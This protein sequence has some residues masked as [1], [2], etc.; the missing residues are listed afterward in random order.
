[1][2]SPETKQQLINLEKGLPVAADVGIFGADIPVQDAALVLL[3]VPFELT[4]SYGKG[5]ING[6]H[7]ISQASSQLDLYD[8]KWGPV[9][10]AG[11]ALMPESEE[12]RILSNQNADHASLVIT[13]IEE[14]LAPPSDATNKVNGASRQ[15]NA[16]VE[17]QAR[18]LLQQGKKVGLMGGDHSTP[19]GLIKA[20][21]EQYQEQGFGILHFDAHHDLRKAYE[22]FTYSH[23]SIMYNV[24]HE[25]NEVKK[26]VSVAIRDFSQEEHLF[27]REHPKIATFYDADLF[28]SLAEG[29]SFSQVAQKIIAELP[30]HVYLSFDI[31][32]LD[33]SCC[34][35][36]GT[37]VPGGL[38]F[39]QAIYLIEKV[40][41]SGR[42]IIGFDLTETAPHPT[43]EWDGNVAARILYK[44]CGALITSQKIPALI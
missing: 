13:A 31:D 16:L 23:A 44:M 22:G 26:L 39:Q 14:G 30:E 9:Y 20:L 29:E 41:T 40:V 10:K 27:A 2:V 24:V 5:T 12:I 8:L 1:M 36:T 25:V 7:A 15:M 17:K 18:E 4:T 33:P 38:S 42:I 19:L 43:S 34:P 32:A 6:A 3:P 21:G 35:S 28:A 11:I 37:P